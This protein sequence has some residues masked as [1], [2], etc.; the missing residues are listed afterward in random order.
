[1]M[2][3]K[4]KGKLD[5]KF[6]KKQNP[7]TKQFISAGLDLLST[8]LQNREAS[9]NEKM[10]RNKMG[11]DQVFTPM[12]DMSRGDYTAN[13]GYFRPDQQVPTQFTGYNFES[14]Y[15]RMGGSYKK[16]GEYYL[17]QDEIDEIIAMGGQ[18]EF[19]D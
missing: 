16:G 1:M 8:G 10:F 17:T 7:Y 2:G 11:A 12:Q 14:P 4:G 19:L 5:V 13:E 18:I 9:R 15:A 6:G 3:E